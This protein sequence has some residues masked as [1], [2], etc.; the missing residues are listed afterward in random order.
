MTVNVSWKVLGLL[1]AIVLASLLLVAKVVGY[2]IH[3]VFL[4][5]IAVAALAL[6]ARHGVRRATHAVSRRGPRGR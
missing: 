2:Y 4:G 1:T 6:L 3:L 5:L